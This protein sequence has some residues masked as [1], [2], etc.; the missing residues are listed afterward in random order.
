M[1]NADVTPASLGYAAFPVPHSVEELELLVAIGHNVRDFS[2]LTRPE[3]NGLLSKLEAYECHGQVVTLLRWR[4]DH[5]VEGDEELFDD[6][7]WLLRVQFLGLER[8]DDF[9]ETAKLA[10]TRLKLPFASVRIHI[11][12]AILG[13][14]NWPDQA[15]L[16]RAIVD[17]FVDNTQKVTLLERLALIYEKKLY[18]ENEVEPVFSRIL[19]LDK[20]NIKARRFYKLWYMQAMRWRDVA[21][22]LEA[23]I[24]ASRNTH[25]RQRAAHELAQLYLYNLNDAA[26]AREI[27]LETCGNSQLDIRQT[28]MEAQERLELYDELV[29]TLAEAEPLV[30]D[31]TELAAV[32]LKQG[33][34][35]MKAGKPER[36][37]E[38]LR[39]GIVNNPQLL[40][41]YEA[42][43]TALIDSGKPTEALGV[44]EELKAAVHLD[45]SKASL[46]E[47][48]ARAR[49]LQPFFD[50]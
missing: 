48:L 46:E 14:E 33:L 40:L 30:R 19:E 6:S 44:L 34:V 36:A 12:E 37:V 9:L 45:S 5:G 21:E 7:L 49:K 28:L 50:A 22:Q 15:S 27:L 38:C 26:R 1:M 13:N 8:F 16:Y 25:E 23:L 43:V 18:L 32:K 42:L 4:M 29:A 41:A 47:M 35:S 17:N 10:V 39:E 24:E 3:Q 31:K 11:S 20:L 2:R